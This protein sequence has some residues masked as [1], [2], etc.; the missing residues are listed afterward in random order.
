MNRKNKE[1]EHVLVYSTDPQPE[2]KCPQ[3]SQTLSKCD[4]NSQ[5]LQNVRTIK[6]AVRME[7]KGRGGKAVTLLSRLPS[8]EKFLKDFCKYLKTALGSGGTYYIENSEGIIEI[9]GDWRDT[10]LEVAQKYLKK[11]N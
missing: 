10:V 11:Q 7:K 5:L 8:S 4:C 2:R 3:C 9:Q 1:P 6:P